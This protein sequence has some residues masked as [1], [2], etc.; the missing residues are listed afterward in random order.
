LASLLFHVISYREVMATVYYTDPEY[1]ERLDGQDYPKVSPKAAHSLVQAA[2]ISLL[3]SLAAERGKVLP[4]MRCRVGAVDG[5]NS[6]LVP[7]IAVITAERWRSLRTPPD[8][9]E[10]PF[11]PDIAIEIRSPGQ[12]AKLRARKIA[13]YLATGSFVVL[14][15]DPSARVIE[16][17]SAEAVSR[18]SDAQRFGDPH[19]TWLQFDVADVFRDLDDI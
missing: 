1:I 6:H 16:A 4:E 15:V 17:H 14:D 9:E 3:R 13:R 7:D 11:A 2:L 8:R 5:T 19:F 12:S 10:P 18:F